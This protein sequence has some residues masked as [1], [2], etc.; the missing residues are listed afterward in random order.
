M[1]SDFLDI[2]EDNTAQE[3]KAQVN[4]R[5][6][7]SPIK[8]DIKEICKNVKMPDFFQVFVFMIIFH[9]NVIYVNRV[10]SLSEYSL[11]CV[12]VSPWNKL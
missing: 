12:P 11:K 3:Q 8:P 10:V 7:L 5:I 4:M 9:E 2:L 1:R 6:Q